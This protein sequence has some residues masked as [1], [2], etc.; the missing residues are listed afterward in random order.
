MFYNLKKSICFLSLNFLLAINLFAEDAPKE[1]L[2]VVLLL[3]TS[4]SMQITDP[5]RL[6]NEG[7]R[8][9]L[10][11]LKAGD[12][13]SI[14]QFSDSTKILMPPAFFNKDG[15][16]IL[17]QGLS[18][19]KNEGLYTDLYEA[20]KTAKDILEKE[21][22]EGFEKIIV[23]FSDGKLDPDEKVRSKAEALERMQSE[24][25]PDLNRSNVKLYTLSFSDEADKELLKSLAENTKALS[26]FTQ[27]ANKIH[28]SFSK[29]FL[30]VK[31]PQIIPISEKGLKLDRQIDEATFYITKRNEKEL[32]IITPEGQK[33][34]KKKLSENIKWFSG[35]L[36]EIIT[37]TKPQ[38]GVWNFLG[39]ISKDDF[40]TV[41]TKLKLEVKSSVNVF[42]N[43]DQIITVSIYD[44]NK[45]VSL[46]EIINSSHV[47]Y[48][49][50][51]T[52]KVSLPVLTGTLY[53][54]GKNGDEKSLDG[55]FSTSINIEK[56]GEYELVVNFTSPTFERQQR[57]PLRVKQKFLFLDLYKEDN[58]D[59]FKVVV[60]DE[61][62]KYKKLTLFVE[63]TNS[64]NKSFKIPLNSLVNDS[65]VFLGTAESLTS[66]DYKIIAK[67]SATSQN[68]INVNFESG[69]LAFKKENIIV[70]KTKVQGKK[71]KEK[72]VREVKE[73]VK[74]KSLIFEHLS[75]L[76]ANI[77]I[78]V[79]MFVWI[80]RNSKKED[81]FDVPDLKITDDVS[82]KID[83][84][85]EVSKKS[86]VDIYSF[87][88]LDDGIDG[89]LEVNEPQEVPP[90]SDEEISSISAISEVQNDDSKVNQ[91][92]DETTNDISNDEEE[93]NEIENNEKVIENDDKVESENKKD[94]QLKKKESSGE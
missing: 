75:V 13:L 87:T 8:L 69:E 61:V 15:L 31:K 71:A 14:V 49:V 40:A 23:L 73:E 32:V 90:L 55:I 25:L 11:F 36:F 62:K 28:D 77:I 4:G 46:P 16:G 85:G 10:Q 47:T 93:K 1:N 86:E 19:M 66:G 58:K 33:I 20:I 44:N 22:N 6:R 21:P 35:S 91:V 64:L 18:L 3:D 45:L 79:F 5:L 80:K 68:G 70:E 54:N 81:I 37:V 24:V 88:F 48:Q 67:L 41:L 51:P 42:N 57:L 39:A 7:V 83:A 17:S 43:E 65:K 9:F 2:D 53:D 12:K 76:F 60:D 34:T 29:L 94:E 50:I 78:F 27:D 74:K 38:E 52:D 89:Q 59:M 63:A 82:K 26:W 56:T 30:A 92:S 72:K 84:L